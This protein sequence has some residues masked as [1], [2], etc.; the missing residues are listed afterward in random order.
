VISYE[1]FCQIHDLHQRQALNAAQ[2]SRVLNLDHKT[3]ATWLARP[4]FISR[5]A[6]KRRYKVTIR[7]QG[8]EAGLYPLKLFTYQFG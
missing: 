8:R 7:P 5:A 1:Q 6:A 3:V 4:H 2:I